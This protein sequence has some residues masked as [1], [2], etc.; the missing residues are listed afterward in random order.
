MTG[1]AERLEMMRDSAALRMAKGN[2]ERYSVKRLDIVVEDQYEER[3]VLSAKGMMK[4]CW[5]CC[6]TYSKGCS[7]KCLPPS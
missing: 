4:K 6:W 2:R 1:M 3:N 7:R 5:V